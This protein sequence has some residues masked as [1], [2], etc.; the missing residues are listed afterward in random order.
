MMRALAVIIGI[1]VS[2]AV[3]FLAHRLNL[4]IYPDAIGTI[5]VSALGG[6]F[7][8]IVTGVLTDTFMMMFNSKALYFGIV[9]AVVAIYTAWYVRKRGLR[10]IKHLAVFIVG[11]GIIGGGLS[12]IIQWILFSGPQASVI[13]DLLNAINIQSVVLNF[14]FFI[15]INISI[16]I[17]EKGFSTAIVLLVIHF[18]PK[19]IV[20][21]I[22]NGAWKRQAAISIRTSSGLDWFKVDFSSSDLSMEEVNQIL[23]AYRTK[24]KYVRIRGGFYK[25]DDAVSQRHKKRQQYRRFETR[26]K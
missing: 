21:H 20:T 19:D 6:L 23:K 1:A 26:R 5:G 9:N 7:P 2:V 24:K 13:V 10:R 3:S 11:A 14:L 12:G 17:L 18:L 25:T 16:N 8:G 15:L 4:P 22:K